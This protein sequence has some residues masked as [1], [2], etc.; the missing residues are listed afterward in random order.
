MNSKKKTRCSVVFL[1]IGIAFCIAGG[2]LSLMNGG[3]SFGSGGSEKEPWCVVEPEGAVRLGDT[4]E[5]VQAEEGYAFYELTFSVRNEGDA[6][7]YYQMP[8]LYY[9]GEDYDAVY[10]HYY[11]EESEEEAEE[12]LFDGYYEPCV[13]PGRTGKASEVV[14]IRDGVERIT[15]S[16][17]PGYSMEEVSFKI[18]IGKE[19]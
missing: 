5:G 11:W 16:Y 7:A 10:D 9:E 14:Q 15:A 4:Y 13:P 2:A 3:L 1:I 6:A 17:Y 8:S 12:L 18:V 19:E